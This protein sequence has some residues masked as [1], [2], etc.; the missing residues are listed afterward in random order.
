MPAR[1]NEDG[2]LRRL[3][4]ETIRR[5]NRLDS[6]EEYLAMV[7]IIDF[8]A[9]DEIRDAECSCDD[10]SCN[11]L[12]S[13]VFLQAHLREDEEEA[14]SQIDPPSSEPQPAT[15]APRSDPET[16]LNSDAF[17]LDVDRRDLLNVH[18]KWA[19]T[20]DA[21]RSMYVTPA[22]K[23]CITNW[24]FFSLHSDNALVDCVVDEFAKRLHRE[25]MQ[26]QQRIAV[27]STE[28]ITM[29]GWQGEFHRWWRTDPR[30][31]GLQLANLDC[32]MFFHCRNFHYTLIAAELTPPC[33]IHI[34]D[35]T[36]TRK[37]LN[38][39]DPDLAA[40]NGIRMFLDRELQLQ[41]ED[42]TNSFEFKVTKRMN[43]PQQRDAVSCGIYALCCAESRLQ[44][45]RETTTFVHTPGAFI[46]NLRMRMAISLLNDGPIASDDS[47]VP[48]LM[49]M[50]PVVVD[51]D[52]NDEEE[53]LPD[54]DDA[55]GLG[56]LE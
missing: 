4:D 25:A 53:D 44:Y 49:T 46:S 10:G 14:A 36:T 38:K 13:D 30:Y 56:D 42:Q 24:A 48:V 34:Y 8:L 18:R 40:V 51:L 32:V 27:F 5:Y 1:R 33:A 15:T 26:N 16:Q 20:S 12:R 28:F 22:L 41:T 19:A 54:D 47:N 31:Q 7:K 52:D 37:R 3:S 21:N 23:N 29:K 43:C 9:N 6:P 11:C 35:S 45:G 39:H 50:N 2:R 55:I 17:V